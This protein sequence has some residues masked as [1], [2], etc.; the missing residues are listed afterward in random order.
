[1][2]LL[3]SIRSRLAAQREPIPEDIEGALVRAVAA[4]LGVEPDQVDPTLALA[5]LGID[6]SG[7]MALTTQ[8]EDRMGLELTPT[9]FYRHP[10]L[11]E[12]ARALSEL[13]GADR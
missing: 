1:M 5:D 7:A 8:L 11:R 12:A 13:V 3:D 9:F 6:S 2:S 10:T 4:R